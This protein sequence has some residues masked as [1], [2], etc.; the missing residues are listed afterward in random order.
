MD[1][2]L[3]WIFF[4]AFIALLFC[5]L[6][7]IKME[8]KKVLLVYG[9][10]L[11]AVPV[12]LVLIALLVMSVCKALGSS[13][14]LFEA[15]RVFFTTFTISSMALCLA[16]LACKALWPF[17]VEAIIGF[18]KRYNTANLGRQPLSFAA[19]NEAK[20]KAAVSYPFFL[21]SLLVFWAIWFKAVV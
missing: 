16:A 10:G 8:R 14:E 21:G 18:H 9:I 1:S 3:R 12:L 2:P 7:V 13:G 5:V 11:V 6:F 19:R 15:F 4:L 20:I 17:M